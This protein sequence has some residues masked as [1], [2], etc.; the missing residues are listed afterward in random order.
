M[1]TIE[2]AVRR[3]VNA[4]ISRAGI[5]SQDK[6]LAFKP[7]DL[8]LI[9]NSFVFREKRT[10][11]TKKSEKYVCVHVT[12]GGN[13]SR[14]PRVA[15]GI[16][17]NSDF[18]RIPA[19]DTNKLNLV[20]LKDALKSELYRL[21]NLVFILIGHI[22]DTVINRHAI[23]NSDYS[24]LVWDPSSKDSVKLTAPT[25]TISDARNESEVWAQ[26]EVEFSRLEADIPEGLPDAF[27]LAIEKLKDEAVA[28]LVL[29]SHGNM[30][31]PNMTES[32]VQVL[33]EQRDEYVDALTKSRNEKMVSNDILRIA[34]NFASDAITFIR[35]IVSIC[36]LKPVVLWGTMDK[37]FALAEALR[38]LP[39]HRHRNKPAL[40][41]YRATIADARNSAFHNLFPFR[42]SLDVSLPEDSLQEA[43]M[44]IFSE[45][46]KKK[47]NVL[48]YQDKEL[49]DL[50]FEFTR[51]RD[52]QVSLQFWESNLKVM[53]ATIEL[54]DATGDFLA[55]LL[56]E[57]GT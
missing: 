44:R 11:K 7:K 8:L 1:A 33:Q 43:K 52:R 36:D 16:S 24:E 30:H 49:V 45:H 32:I 10:I 46:T 18:K 28:N 20:P 5:S 34:Y 41:N 56:V 2:Q 21:G 6:A 12:S 29:P 27:A 53:D 25:I 22:D 38:N 51:A 40:S 9:N 23:Q 4:F 48:L 17:I 57:V 50:L 3:R 14:S 15:T 42:K 35:L 39:W 55:E 37:H 26:I 31:S 47:H 19:R 54:C 13:F